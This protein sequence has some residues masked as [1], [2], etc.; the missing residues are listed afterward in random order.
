MKKIL[1]SLG[2][3]YGCASAGMVVQSVEY[4]GL[5]RMS[6][7]VAGELTGVQKGKEVDIE[8]IDSSIKTLYSQGYFEDI[9]IENQNGVL[10]YHF[11]ELPV[12]AQI[13]FTGYS[14]S[15][16][17]DVMKK[18]GVKV[19]DTYHI[20]KVLESKKVVIEGLEEDGYVNTVVETETKPIGTG[21][22]IELIYTVNKGEKI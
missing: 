4:D 5:T 12:I 1:L 6:P 20:E 17:E 10:T 21:G 14:D 2:I 3:V 22:G 9:W 19:G 7:L 8:T 15:D 18:L 16:Q 11:K 13:T